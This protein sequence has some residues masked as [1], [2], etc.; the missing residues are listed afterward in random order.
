[1]TSSSTYPF[2]MEHF[3]EDFTGR[4]AINVLGKRLLRAAAMHAN[5]RQF[6]VLHIDGHTYLW[7]LSRLVLEIDHLP[8]AAEQGSITTWLTAAYRY[9]TERCYTMADHFGRPLGQAH[10]VW[11]LIDADSRRPVDIIDTLGTDFTEWVDTRHKLNL[12]RPQRIKMEDLQ[13]VAQRKVY[14][15][16]LDKNGH[17]NSIRYIDLALDTWSRQ[18]HATHQLSRIEVSYSRE[19]IWD[20]QLTILR[21]SPLSTTA[22]E[23]T[24]A[25]VAITRRGKVACQCNLKFKEYHNPIDNQTISY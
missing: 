21:S 5:D 9:F 16:D 10:S 2:D 22:T 19:S 15:S 12:G 13:P 17:L 11:A 25:Q 4:M 6:E 7:V 3:D 20:D 1:M 18:F 23:P 14:Y 24:Q 8:H